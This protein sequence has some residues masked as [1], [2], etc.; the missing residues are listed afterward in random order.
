MIIEDFKTDLSE[1][2]Q[3]KLKGFIGQAVEK[4]LQK[5]MK[6]ITK[7]NSLLSL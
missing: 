1:A 7:K 2:A 5:E 6:K 3:A 4:K